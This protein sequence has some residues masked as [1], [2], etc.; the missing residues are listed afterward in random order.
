MMRGDLITRMTPCR[1][2]D[3]AAGLH[4]PGYEATLGESWKPRRA[5]SPLRDRSA[6]EPGSGHGDCDWKTPRV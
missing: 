2:A 3:F 1:R 4:A 5:Q 6:V